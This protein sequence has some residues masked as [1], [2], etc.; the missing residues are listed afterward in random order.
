MGS[1]A[2]LIRGLAEAWEVRRDE[3]R[4]EPVITILPEP[5]VAGVPEI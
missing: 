3:F 5:A 2:K 4:P 1:A